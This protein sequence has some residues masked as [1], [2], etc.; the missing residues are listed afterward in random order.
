MGG[1]QGAGEALQMGSWAGGQGP[2]GRRSATGGV[3]GGGQ[4]PKGRGAGAKG[5]RGRGQ[6]AGA[7]DQPAICEQ[8]ILCGN[9][10]LLVWVR[11]GE[12]TELYW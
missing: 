3:M 12:L 6:G 2:E 11:G 9:V 4:G 8:L 5:P 10:A 1:E 7:F